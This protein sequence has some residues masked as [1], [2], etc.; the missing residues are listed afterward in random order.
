MIEA[1]ITDA[2]LVAHL[3]ALPPDGLHFF[4]LGSPD[5]PPGGEL[6]GALV[7]ATRLVNRMRA[8]H[9]LGLLESSMLG[10]A[11]VAAALLASTLKGED[12]LGL[13]LDCEGPAQGWSVEASASTGSFGV[14]GHLFL[15]AF[16]LP[17]VPE[18]FDTAPLV[19][20]G[21]LTLTRRSEGATQPFTG[22]VA[23]KTGRLAEDL[24]VAFLES[25]QTPTAFDLGI[26]FDREGRLVGAGGLYL[27]ALPGATAS[28]LERAES[29]L[30]GFQ[31]IGRYF[32]EGGQAEAWLGASFASMGLVLR[33][34]AP[35]A[36]RCNCEK[37]RFAKF[38]ANVGS[39]KTTSQA[40]GSLFGGPA[41]EPDATPP[42]SPRRSL[43]H[44]LAEEGPWPVEAVCHQCG[45]RYHWSREEL[46]GLIAAQA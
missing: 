6:R 18:S 38:M 34:S 23:L 42:A 10:Q 8:N 45:S 28:L 46:L 5:G 37:E 33:G 2:R 13:R 36:F 41:G 3:G 32:A 12:R 19:G 26:H 15:D 43:L 27:Q 16:D 44:D 24:A 30:A 20:A 4:T 21:S 29:A 11:C 17:Q 7:H 9:G 35:V 25:E 14:R 31:P 40:P 39:E 22:R 1:P